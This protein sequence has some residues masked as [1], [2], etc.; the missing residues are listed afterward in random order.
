[1]KIGYKAPYSMIK[2]NGTN[3]HIPN[4]AGPHQ[5][6][7]K[8]QSQ[9]NSIKIHVVEPVKTNWDSSIAFALKKNKIFR[10]C[11]D[12]CKLNAVTV[13]DSYSIPQMRKFIVSLQLVNL[14]SALDVNRC[15]WKTSHDQYKIK[16]RC[17]SRIRE[18]FWG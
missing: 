2:G 6:R 9:Q 5:R 8:G 10:F 3:I 11:V 17:L 15:Y 4:C 16:R 13:Q 1:M 7:L 12:Y 18:P 14:I